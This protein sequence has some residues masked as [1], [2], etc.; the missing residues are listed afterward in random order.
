MVHYLILL[1][2]NHLLDLN[3]DLQYQISLRKNKMKNNN[4]F[5]YFYFGPCLIKFTLSDEL[6]NELLE[7]GKKYNPD[8][9]N[10]LAGHLNEEFFYSETDRN[11]FVENFKSYL[12]DYL[13]FLK[14]YKNKGIYSYSHK[15]NN[16]SLKLTSL[17]INYMKKNEFNPLH[18]HTGDL[19][20][21]IYLKVPNKLKEENKNYIGT[22]PCG[23][24]GISFVN[25]LKSDKMTISEV[26]LFPK[27]KECYIF[28]SKLH[29]MVFPYK[30]DCERISVSGNIDI[31][32]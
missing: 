22:D 15:E 1:D 9:R 6:C 2:H 10:D 14:E 13:K 11:W 5:K 25:D 32:E 30:S 31:I 18:T 4:N 12:Q 29:H 23:P 8:A 21:V 3:T 16:V 19:S 26:N 7:R 24:G 17:W 20:F 28:P 27:E